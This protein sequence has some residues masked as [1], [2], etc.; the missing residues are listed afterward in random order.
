MENLDKQS[1]LKKISIKDIAIIVLIILLCGMTYCGSPIDRRK[2][3]IKALHESNDSLLKDNLNKD[4][5]YK[6]LQ[7]DMVSLKKDQTNLE[8]KLKTLN[9]SINI[10]NDEKTKKKNTIR[11]LNA[12]G[13]VDFFSD[14]LNTK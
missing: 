9:D 13:A 10:I 8:T 7:D 1:I 2:S 14:Y 6:S 3:E 5:L 11:N 12:D 4:K